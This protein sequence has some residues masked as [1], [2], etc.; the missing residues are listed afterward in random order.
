MNVIKELEAMDC[1]DT[2]AWNQDIFSNCI[3]YI[4]DHC[5]IPTTLQDELKAKILVEMGKNLTL[6]QIENLWKL[7]NK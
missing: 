4:K 7:A 6:E 1:D 3:E 5:F 2:Q